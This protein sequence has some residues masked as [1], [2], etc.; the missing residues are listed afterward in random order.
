MI[1]ESLCDMLNGSEAD[2][3]GIALACLG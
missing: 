3:F 1:F 2:G